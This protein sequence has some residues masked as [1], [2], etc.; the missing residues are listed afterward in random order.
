MDAWGDE[1]V[2]KEGYTSWRFFLGGGGERG[3]QR[4]SFCKAYRVVLASLYR[5]R[6]KDFHF[7][8]LLLF[9]SF[10]VIAWVV[11]VYFLFQ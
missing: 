9:C 1:F 5:G 6:R 8:S 7:P 2:K 3:C 4:I 11:C 10:M